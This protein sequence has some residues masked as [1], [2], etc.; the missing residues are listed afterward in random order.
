MDDFLWELNNDADDIAS[1]SMGNFL[2]QY[3]SCYRHFY[4]QSNVGVDEKSY[5]KLQQDG[6][7]TF[8]QEEEFIGA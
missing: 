2:R 3:G 7:N 6:S 1:K 8:H 4:V 5:R